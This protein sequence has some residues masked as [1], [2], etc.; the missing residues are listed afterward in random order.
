MCTGELGSRYH[1]Q[2]KMAAVGDGTIWPNV[3][4]VWGVKWTRSNDELDLKSDREEGI[5]Q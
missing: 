5:C 3:K 4:E 1:R 2:E